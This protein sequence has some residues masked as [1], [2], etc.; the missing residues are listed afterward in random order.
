MKLPVLSLRM[1]DL[2]IVERVARICDVAIQKGRG[3]LSHYK[4]QYV[5]SLRGKA[6]FEIMFTL[7]PLLGVRRRAKISELLARW[8]HGG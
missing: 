4:A 1:T 3:A 7:F 5:I 2:D 8:E 6:A